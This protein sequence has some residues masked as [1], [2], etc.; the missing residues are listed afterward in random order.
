[1]QLSEFFTLLPF[2]K[3]LCIA[4]Y[5]KGDLP[6][7][8]LDVIVHILSFASP[9]SIFIVIETLQL[10]DLFKGSSVLRNHTL[11]KLICRL[12]HLPRH[13]ETDAIDRESVTFGWKQVWGEEAFMSCHYYKRHDYRNIVIHMP[14]KRADRVK[15]KGVFSTNLDDVYIVF[16]MCKKELCFTYDEHGYESLYI[17]EPRKV[18]PKKLSVRK[19]T[20][21]PIRED[22]SPEKLKQVRV[23]G[24][25]MLQ[26][27]AFYLHSRKFKSDVFS[28]LFLYNHVE[29]LL[30]TCV[31]LTTFV[32]YNSFIDTIKY[33]P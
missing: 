8:P 9:Q 26:I 23:L 12:N 6:Q 3:W 31:D 29:K 32:D 24:Q 25:L 33:S 15:L 13:D 18:W 4:H 10:H 17:Q 20:R 1:M 19:S 14:Y 28:R 21:R 7:L 5:Y 2:D 30:H 16:R 11:R 27:R 22:I